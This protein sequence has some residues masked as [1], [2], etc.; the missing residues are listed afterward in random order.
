MQWTLIYG[1]S[2]FSLLK[3]VVNAAKKMEVV[4]S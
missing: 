3:D 1:S 4:A 2:H